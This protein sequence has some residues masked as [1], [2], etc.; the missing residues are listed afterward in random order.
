MSDHGFFLYGYRTGCGC[1]V[2]RRLRAEDLMWQLDTDGLRAVMAQEPTTP[3]VG[4]DG[5]LFV[6]DV[7]DAAESYGEMLLRTM[8]PP[9]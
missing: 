5:P 1:D 2:C 3:I 9:N 4:R 7:R 6:A 8:T